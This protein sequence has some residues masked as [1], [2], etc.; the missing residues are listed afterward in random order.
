MTA[1]ILARHEGIPSGEIYRGWTWSEVWRQLA[2][3]LALHYS[4]DTG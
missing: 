2:L 1:V 3:H 4:T